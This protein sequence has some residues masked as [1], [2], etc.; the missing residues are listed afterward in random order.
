MICQSKKSQ[1]N[2]KQSPIDSTDDF[3]SSESS[4]QEKNN[5]RSKYFHEDEF[6]C[7]MRWFEVN[8]IEA[9]NPSEVHQ[10]F[11]AK[12]RSELSAEIG[13]KVEFKL[14]KFSLLKSRKSQL[15]KLIWAGS[16]SVYH[17]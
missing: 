10:E 5:L 15:R 13:K 16:S 17:W 6:E 8:K 3:C 12:Q 9:G 1:I 7:I 14:E 2:S 11:S 4:V